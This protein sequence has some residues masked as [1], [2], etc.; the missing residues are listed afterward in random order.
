M[1][2]RTVEDVAEHGYRNVCVVVGAKH[3]Q[4]MVPEFEVR[5]LE[6]AVADFS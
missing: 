1:V 5:G 3:L 2:A 4:G 6:V